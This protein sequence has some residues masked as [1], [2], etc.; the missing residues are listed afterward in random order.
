M[1]F[2]LS[3]CRNDSQGNQARAAQAVSTATTA[4]GRGERSAVGPPAAAVQNLGTWR[5]QFLIAQT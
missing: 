2:F 1:A 3:V 4:C 5:P